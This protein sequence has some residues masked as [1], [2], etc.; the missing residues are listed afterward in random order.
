MRNGT[1]VTPVDPGTLDGWLESGEAVVIDVREPFE[2]ASERIPGSRLH[3][4]SQFD[5]AA[6][7]ETFPSK[8][9]VFQCRTGRRSTEAARRYG[10][11]RE[12]QVFHLDG[13][14]EAWKA[15]GKETERSGSAPRIDVMRQVQMTAGSLVLIGVLL[16]A[17]VS[18]W[19]LILSG[20]IGAGLLF[21]GASGWCGMAMFLSRMPWNRT[22][23]ATTGDPHV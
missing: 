4:L 15:A 20:F 1:T 21:A 6:L 13:G 14:I 7:R 22:A 18:P 10:A 16:G 17:L 5:A 12:D 9:I 2:H 19:F 11:G 3:A 8:R 23:L